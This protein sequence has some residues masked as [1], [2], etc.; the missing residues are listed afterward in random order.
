MQGTPN[1]LKILFCKGVSG[2]IWLNSAG[3]EVVEGLDGNLTRLRVIVAKSLSIVLKLWTGIP[4][5]V[6]LEKTLSKVFGERTAG[7][8]TEE[9]NDSAS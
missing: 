9:R 3:C 7:A 1:N 5:S 4:S 8:T 6:R 2:T